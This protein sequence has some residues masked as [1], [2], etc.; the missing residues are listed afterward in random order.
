MDAVAQAEEPAG[1]PTEYL[2]KNGFDT[3]AGIEYS[4]GMEEFYLEMIQT[5]AEGYEAKVEEIRADYAAK[6]WTNYRT[7]VHA[8]K[9]TA[10]M[11]GA[12]A[13]SDLALAQEMAA[14][15]GKVEEIDKGCEPLISA[16]TEVVETIRKAFS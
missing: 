1:N 9:G 2:K 12:N 11:V 10:R 6:E 7:R 15:D 14:K 4:A 3:D 5:F 8:L 13:L 16:Y